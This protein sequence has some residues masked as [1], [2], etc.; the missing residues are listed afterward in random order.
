M[1]LVRISKSLEMQLVKVST[2]KLCVKRKSERVYIVRVLTYTLGE[3][4]NK[5]CSDLL[6]LDLPVR[7]FDSWQELQR[8]RKVIK[9]TVSVEVEVNKSEPFIESIGKWSELEVTT[10]ILDSMVA[11]NG[12]RGRPSKIHRYQCVWI[13]LSQNSAQYEGVQSLGNITEILIPTGF[14]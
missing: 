4:Q 12:P 7:S 13:Y 8:Q 9:G 10:V 2:Q 3:C 11:E 1:A 14:I 6:W 5:K